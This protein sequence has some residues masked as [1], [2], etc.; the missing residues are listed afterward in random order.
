MTEHLNCRVII[1]FKIIIDSKLRNYMFLI[2]LSIML[3]I[4][5]DCDFENLVQ[6]LGHPDQKYQH[7]LF[8][9]KET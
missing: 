1:G 9:F 6:V 4:R 8:F 5:K 3:S 7:I 2:V